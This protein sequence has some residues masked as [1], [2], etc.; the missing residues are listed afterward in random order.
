VIARWSEKAQ[1][2]IV[3]LHAFLSLVNPKAAA[4]VVNSMIA[5]PRKLSEYPRIGERLERYDPRE[6]RRIFVGNYEMRYEITASEVFVL[7][8]WHT[9]EDR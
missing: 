6:V 9:R 3:R 2:D 4:S 5:A 7:R 1:S 8:V